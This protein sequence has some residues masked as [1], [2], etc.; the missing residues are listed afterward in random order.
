MTDA[1]LAKCGLDA[2]KLKVNAEVTVQYNRLGKPDALIIQ[3]Y[4]L[5]HRTA[6]APR[7]GGEVGR[8]TRYIQ[9]IEIEN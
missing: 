2:G 8:S 3:S 9:Q 6:P 7:Q 4:A 1:K 5:R